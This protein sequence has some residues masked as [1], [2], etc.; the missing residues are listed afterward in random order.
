MVNSV[1]NFGRNGLADWL[2]QRISAL[3]IGVYAVFLLGFFVC[4]PHMSYAQ[5]HRFFSCTAVKVGS[6]LAL[7]CICA[8]AWIG[9]WT[10][11]TDY[12]NCA[13]LR[14]VLEILLVLLL[15]TYVIWGIS[16]FWR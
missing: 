11:F 7:L 4:H 2:V 6:M 1:T 3:V 14:L 13:R 12:I 8:H 9:L 16:I 15:L 10:V 5:W